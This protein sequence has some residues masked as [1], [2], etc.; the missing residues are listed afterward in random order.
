[1]MENIPLYNSTLLATYMDL[2]QERY[3]HVNVD[4]L[5]EYAKISPYELEDRGHWLTQT[6]ID[7]FHDYLAEHTENPQIAREAGRF[8]VQSKSSSLLRQYTAGFVT[9]AMAYWM[10]GKISSTLTRHLHF[11]INHIAA[12]KVEMIVTPQAGVKEKPYQCENRIGLFEGLVKFFTNKYPTIEH[13]ECVHKG[14]PSCKY[15]I[16]WKTTPAMIWKLIAGYS[17]ALSVIASLILLFF[18]SFHS[19]ITYSLALALISA[20][21]HLIAE[22]LAR[23]DL[24]KSVESQQNVGDQLMQQFNIRYNELALIKEIGE[25]ASNILDPQ[26]L[27]NFIADSLRK[28]LQFTRSMIMLTNP[29]KTK[30]IYTTGYGY[31]REEEELL[32]NTDF[33]LCNP[34]ST[35]IF[36]LTYRDQKPFLVNDV[37]DIKSKLSE[38]SLKFMEKLG[39]KTFTCIPIIYEGKSE[40]IFA[41]DGTRLNRPLIQS[42]LSLLMGIARQ[43]GISL[44]NAIAHK[45]LKENE[46][47]FRNLSNNSPDIIYQLDAEGR[48][49]YINPAWK[50]IFG[51]NK[52]EV[53]GKSLT[54][55]IQDDDR[56]D[57]IQIYKKIIADKSTI[58]D[59]NFTILDNKGL[60]HYV[61][62]TGTPDS[63][64]EGD[65]I[66]I[67]GTLKDITKL[68]N[69]ETQLLQASKME[70]VGTLTG[71]IAHDFN[72]ILQAIMGYNE[73]MLLEKQ[74]DRTRKLYL[75]NTR[76]LTQRAI[77]LVR[78]LLLF[79]RKVE[80]LSKMI[81]INNEIRNMQNLLAKS[82]PRMIEIKTNLCEDIFP[83]NADPTQIG[84]VIMNLVIN[85]R[86]AI[87][88]GGS[89]TVTTSNVVL[90]EDT[91]MNGCNIRAGIYARLSVT[92]TGCGM[93]QEIL[94]HIFE[95]FFTTK[96]PGKG[97]G[98]GLA[99]VYGVVKSHHGFIYCESELEKGTTFH[100]LFPALKTVESKNVIESPQPKELP[101]G[102]ETILLVDDERS[103][104]D[105][106][107]DTLSLYDYKVIT[108]E[109]GEKAVEIYKAQQEKIQ[110]VILDMIMP[111]K[112]GK[113]C[114]AELISINPRIRVLMSSGYSTPQQ[115]EELK[116]IGAAGFISKPYHPED[117]LVAVRKIIDNRN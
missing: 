13:N 11:K 35:G 61:T 65:I 18:V 71:G 93:E 98:L 74:D 39:V 68:R 28:R 4:K 46:E 53:C 115:I 76:D 38:K 101:R 1:M 113:K 82:I 89:I 70:A 72:N 42:D 55:F 64:A 43:I 94:E 104:L 73:L 95:P 16:S 12:N 14:D 2:L 90:T 84:Q 114:L 112:G 63:N 79:S 6:Q 108:A 47:R 111:G 44:N 30:L 10:M 45:K 20:I 26:Q 22:Q 57:F 48:I 27:L 17:S 9:P 78:Q 54:E 92:D 59:R 81:S 50:E 40:G 23:R 97:T 67:T 21:C 106:C 88:D 116:K 103:I 25:A 87:G 100:I 58:R 117:L 80:P 5:L 85:A 107:E 31:T 96:E 83:I 8:V 102:T 36:Y 29:E 69:M 75:N 109:N 15:I 91:Y 3:P 7:R 56:D 33:N 66:G 60:P 32:K 62:F 110:L 52:N 49:T 51:H 77:Q 19:W 99:V 86:D 105:I 41:V 24:N 34:Q 37:S